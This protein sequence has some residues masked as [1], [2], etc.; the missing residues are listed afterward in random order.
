MH[1]VSTELFLFYE[2]DSLLFYSRRLH[3]LQGNLDRTNKGK[4]ARAMR[5]VATMSEGI[6]QG[7]REATLFV[8]QEHKERLLA[9]VA[10]LSTYRG[11]SAIMRHVKHELCM[12]TSDVLSLDSP[13]MDCLVGPYSGAVL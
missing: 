7:P 4:N 5:F 11:D 8:F 13:T 2:S 1:L 9:P 6:G 10:G 3:D 12:Q